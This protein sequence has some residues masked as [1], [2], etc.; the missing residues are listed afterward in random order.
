MCERL[1][2]LEK[3][4]IVEQGPTRDILIRPA[5]P[6]TQK[7]LASTPRMPVLS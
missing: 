4:G 3:G 6:Y 1:V 5:H 2:V 7:M